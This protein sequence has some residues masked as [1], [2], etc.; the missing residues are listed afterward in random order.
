[1]SWHKTISTFLVFY[2]FV[3]SPKQQH[4]I[5]VTFVEWTM[6]IFLY[7]F[8]SLS[9]SVCVCVLDRRNT[10]IWDWNEMQVSR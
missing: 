7:P 8:L 4:W 2:G 9:L 10:V 5:A 6:G 3:Y 1:M